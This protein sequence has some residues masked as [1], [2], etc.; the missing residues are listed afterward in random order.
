MDIGKNMPRA[1]IDVTKL[2]SK[3]TSMFNCTYITTT[4]DGRTQA[5]QTLT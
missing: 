4:S 3:A 2:V 1:I 5:G